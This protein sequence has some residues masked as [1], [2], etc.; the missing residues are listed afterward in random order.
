[1]DTDGPDWGHYRTFLAVLRT[2]SLSAAARELGLTQPTVGRHVEALERALGVRLFVRTHRGLAPTARAEAL[3]P[4]AEA[5]AASV[6]SLLRVATAE[7]A[8]LRGTVRVSAPEVVGS[9]I[10]PGILAELVTSAPGIDVELSLSNQV[11]DLLRRDADIAVRM[12]QPTQGSLVVQRLGT[13]EIGAFA[14]RDYL[15][16]RG[17]PRTLADL[18]HHHVIGF[19]TVTSDI[20]VLMD[21]FPAAALPRLAFR[22]DDQQAQLALVRAGCGVGFVQR[23]LAQRWPELE[24]LLGDEV[25]VRFGVWLA[26]LEDLRDAP[27]CRA[28]FDALRDGMMPFVTPDR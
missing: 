2:G 18:A 5:V 22:T 10:L 8:A 6:A 25:V 1:M 3:R 16:R 24:P 21:R 15:A 20:R 23:R 9:E 12:V 27:A 26:M 13:I 14:H 11:A 17:T 28:V 7:P 4:R 19:D